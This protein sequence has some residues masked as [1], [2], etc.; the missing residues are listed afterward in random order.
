MTD[1]NSL[2]AEADKLGILNI[3]VNN[4]QISPEVIQAAIDATRDLDTK[5]DKDKVKKKLQKV[6]RFVATQQR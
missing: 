2:L 5:L 1:T 6:D 3:D 4:S